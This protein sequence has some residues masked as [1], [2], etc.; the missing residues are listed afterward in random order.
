M[1]AFSAL[2]RLVYMCVYVCIVCISMTFLSMSRAVIPLR[3]LALSFFLPRCSLFGS[4][5]VYLSYA[6]I[7]IYICVCVSFIGFATTVHSFGGGGAVVVV[8][9]LLLLPLFVMDD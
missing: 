6:F 1:T 7:Y 4:V 9:V 5:G 3:S 8:F 2:E